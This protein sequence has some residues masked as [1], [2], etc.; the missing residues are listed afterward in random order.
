MTSTSARRKAKVE[1]AR[2]AGKC[3]ICLMR[4]VQPG[5]RCW[6]C[7]R[8][9]RIRRRRLAKRGVCVRCGTRKAKGGLYCPPCLTKY[10]K[11]A[12][13]HRKQKKRKGVCPGCGRPPKPGRSMCSLCLSKVRRRSRRIVS[14]RRRLGLCPS[15]GGKREDWRQYCQSCRDYANTYLLED[16]LRV[17]KELLAKY[18]GRC[19]CCL[20][21]ESSFLCVDH[22]FNDGRADRQKR[23]PN[24]YVLYRRL[25]KARRLFRRYQLLCWNCNQAK[26]YYGTCPH[27]A[28][29]RSGP[30]ALTAFG[31]Q[32]MV[33]AS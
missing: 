20:E 8:K 4:P 1:E 28:A 2:R 16:R 19:A 9:L 17:R 5:K 3:P 21:S 14:Q 11:Y 27:Q 32:P 18:G 33:A 13:H 29:R 23:S 24:T 22:V 10:K 26:Q 30:K 6:R 31:R 25:L 12:R 15:C 7:R